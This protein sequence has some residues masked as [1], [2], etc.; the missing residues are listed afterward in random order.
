MKTETKLMPPKIVKAPE[1]CESYLTP[2][3]EYE[4]LLHNNFMKKKSGYGFN[5][6]SDEG[7]E[8]FTSHKGSG[9]LNGQDWIIVERE[10]ESE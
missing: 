1:G 8:I 9:H 10:K 4:V 6:I 7:Y 2:G 3:K 5:I